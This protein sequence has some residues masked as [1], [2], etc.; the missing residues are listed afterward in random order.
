M[1]GV[2]ENGD[3]K[4]KKFNASRK[5]KKSSKNPGRNFLFLALASWG[6]V[7]IGDR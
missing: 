6:G 7:G 1:K 5:R 4:G 2:L 3:L